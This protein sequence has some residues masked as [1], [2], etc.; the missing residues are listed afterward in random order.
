MRYLLTLILVCS[1]CCGCRVNPR[2]ERE[3]ALLRAEILDLEDQ[4]YAL[5]DQCG[6]QS[7]I[8]NNQVIYESGFVEGECLNCQPGS[9][10]YNNP[11]NII[12][13]EA[14]H[15]YAPSGDYIESGVP[16]IDSGAPLIESAVPSAIEPATNGSDIQLE[17]I[18]NSDSDALPEKVSYRRDGNRSHPQDAISAVAVNR[19]LSRGEDIDG[20]PGH[21]GL[22]LL[23]QPIDHDGVIHKVPGKLTVM[24]S[25]SE[26]PNVERQIGFWE[27]TPRETESFFVKDEIDQQGILL[28]LPWDNF[29][30]TEN[31]LKVSVR[32]TT[33]DNRK[34]DTV[35]RLNIDPPANSYSL[36][37]PLVIG[38]IEKDN[39]WKDF[40]LE[41]FDEVEAISEETTASIQSEPSFRVKSP[42]VER[43]ISAPGWRPVR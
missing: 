23:V 26:S 18:P 33:R 24:I 36:D 20:L 42:T 25:E 13:S 2:A 40:E 14:P 34:L 37:D 41:P 6:G 22:T 28:H 8:A 15:T 4:Y 9:I 12:Y 5:K 39:R 7:G 31:K 43:R 19:Q 3:I 29:V 21:E 11:A 17:E 35:V 16:F 38:W 32:Y 27:F 1:F 30:P 10:V